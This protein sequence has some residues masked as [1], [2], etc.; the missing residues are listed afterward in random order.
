MN[1]FIRQA[2]IADAKAIA[3]LISDAIGDIANNLT[4][5]QELPKIIATL[6]QLVKETSNRHSY[7]NT[8]VAVANDTVQGIV[9]LY[10]GIKGAILD[11]Q[12][13]A[14]LAQKGIRLTIDVEAH[15]DEYYIDTICV[16]KEARGLG[17]GTKLLQFA[18]E[19]GRKLGYQKLSLNVELEKLDARRLYERMGFD[20]TE[21]WTIIDEPFHHMVKSLH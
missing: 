8:F 4:G 12:L 5:E 20:V 11:S 19:H 17:I 2:E 10:D 9:V 7:L 13:E 1:I 21:P 18:E 6:E 14:Q 3:P 15:E 16:S